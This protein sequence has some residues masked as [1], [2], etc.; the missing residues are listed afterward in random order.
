VGYAVPLEVADILLGEARDLGEL[1]LVKPFSLRSFPKF[2][3]TSLR[4]SMRA[5]CVFTYYGLSL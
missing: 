5:S 4:I 1:L 3:P 2:R